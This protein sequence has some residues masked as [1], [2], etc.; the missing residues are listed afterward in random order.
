MEHWEVQARL[1]VQDT[2]ACYVR[3]A[4][5]GRFEELAALFAADGTLT[6]DT[7]E[8]RG[9]A[10]IAAFL[11]STKA[12]LAASPTAAGR[13]RHHVSSLRLTFASRD[14]VHRDVVLPGRHRRRS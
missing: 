3:Y 13:I 14:E 1:E 5:G 9:P 7:H 8:L 2:L 10:A 11:T 12:S 6:T 4:D